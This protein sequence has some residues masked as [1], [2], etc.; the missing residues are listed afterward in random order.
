MK[1][2][3]FI[4]GNREDHLFLVCV[5]EPQRL[6]GLGISYTHSLALLTGVCEVPGLCLTHNPASYFLCFGRVFCA[7]SFSQI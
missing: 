2:G 1:V 6:L 5:C 3:I 7:L 4:L